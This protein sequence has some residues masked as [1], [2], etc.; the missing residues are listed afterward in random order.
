MDRENSS[1]GENQPLLS[2]SSVTYAANETDSLIEVRPNEIHRSPSSSS[3]TSDSSAHFT[4]CPAAVFLTVNACLGAGLLNFPHAFQSAG[5]LTVALVAQAILLVL[6]TGALFILSYCTQFSNVD[7]F[8]DLVKYFT[9]KS[10]F[11]SLI[12]LAIILYSFGS[13]LAFIIIVGDQIDRVLSSQI[14]PDFC[15]KWYTSRA[16]TMSIIST[17]TILPL[18]FSKS[19]DFLKYPR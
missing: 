17:C 2:S 19:I 12:S 16:F 5:G 1:R 10:I 4:S 13:C 6:I 18:S 11:K 8:Q 9:R 3:F 15:Y 7:T 14:G